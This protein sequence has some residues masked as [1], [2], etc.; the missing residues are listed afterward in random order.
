MFCE[1]ISCSSL[2]STRCHIIAKMEIN[3]QSKLAVSGSLI[4]HLPSKGA[5]LDNNLTE[6]FFR[7]IRTVPLANSRFSSNKRK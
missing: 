2:T 4:Y 3:H 5:I 1:V 6:P 7:N